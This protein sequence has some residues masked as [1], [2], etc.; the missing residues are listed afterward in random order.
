MRSP[1]VRTLYLIPTMNYTLL[2]TYAR[3][4]DAHANAQGR[5]ITRLR[6]SAQTGELGLQWY[7]VYTANG[8]NM[9]I[10][11]QISV[12]FALLYL[13]EIITDCIHVGNIGNICCKP[14]LI[15]APVF[16]QRVVLYSVYIRVFFTYWGHGHTITG[17]NLSLFGLV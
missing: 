6:I 12:K 1:V 13:C 2:K 5:A 3:L 15:Y 16:I 9:H 4:T 10:S 17:I 8:K 11:A 14:T 7:T